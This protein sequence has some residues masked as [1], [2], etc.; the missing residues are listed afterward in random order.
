MIDYISFSK[1][2]HKGTPF[3]GHCNFYSCKLNDYGWQT[4]TIQGCKE[5]QVHWNESSR[6]IRINGS[7]PYFLKGHNFS[8]SRDEFVETIDV[9]QSLLGVGLWDSFVDS[10]E[11]GV[12]IPV[13]HNPSLYIKNHTA[14]TKSRLNENS[15]GKD[16]GAG[17]WWDNPNVLLKMYDAGKNI[18][19]KQGMKERQVIEES[20]YNPNQHYLKFEVHYK[21]KM[22]LLNDGKGVVL[23]KLQ[24]PSFIEH[25]NCELIQKYELLKPMADIIQP[26]DKKDYSALDVV[27]GEYVKILN[28]NGKTIQDAKKQ[29]Y[30][31]INLAGCLNKPDK[32]SRKQTIKKAFDKM[33]ESEQSQWNVKKQLECGLQ[34]SK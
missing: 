31:A 28:D 24:M 25:L 22:Y 4:Y 27:L 23:E 9:L 32:D 30:S 7:L 21:R 11:Y 20:G 1:C 17:K 26:T 8:Y 19:M 33:R 34:G 10:F 3:L 12:I 16:N 6:E 18:K 29:I 15:R 13:Q 2:L 14:L 5:L